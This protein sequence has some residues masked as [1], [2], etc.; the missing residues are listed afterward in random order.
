MI[1]T[2]QITQTAL[3]NTAII[4]LTIP[5]EEIQTVMGPGIA[6]LMP[7]LPLRASNL[8]ARGSLTI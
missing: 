5:R 3:Q 6:E 4:H 7:L 1:D 8:P 2:P